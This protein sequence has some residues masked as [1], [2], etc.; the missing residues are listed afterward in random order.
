[1]CDGTTYEIRA[2]PGDAPFFDTL[3]HDLLARIEDYVFHREYG[4][5]QVIHFPDDPRDHI[6]WVRQGRVKVTHRDM[7]SLVGSTRE[8]TT[9]ALHGFRSEGIAEMANRR[10]TI[11]YPVALELVAGGH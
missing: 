9:A 4:T 1:M 6:V 5:R 11:R 8:T 7:A 2:F 10:L 3:S